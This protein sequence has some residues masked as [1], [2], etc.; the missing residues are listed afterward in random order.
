MR[1]GGEAEVD[2]GEGVGGEEG[3]EEL[4]LGAAERSSGQ[5]G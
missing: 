3:E 2:D 4:G 1:G 5:G